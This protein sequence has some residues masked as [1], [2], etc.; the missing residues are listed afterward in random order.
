VIPAGGNDHNTARTD[1]T[2][3]CIGVRRRRDVP[4]QAPTGASFQS[5]PAVIGANSRIRW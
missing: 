2:S 1:L 3:E 5:A 4:I